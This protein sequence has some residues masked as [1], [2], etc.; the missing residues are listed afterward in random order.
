MYFRHG[1][2]DS[3]LSFT[4][5]DG[6]QTLYLGE[7]FARRIWIPD[8]FFA[9]GKSVQF[10]KLAMTGKDAEFISLNANGDLFMSR[11]YGYPKPKLSFNLNIYLFIFRIEVVAS[12]PMNV[13]NYPFDRQLCT[14]EMESCKLDRILACL[15]IDSLSKSLFLGFFL[16]G[17]SMS[18]VIYSWRSGK[19]A[20]GMSAYSPGP[21]FTICG[22]KQLAK[23]ESLSS[24][25]YSR[26]VVELDMVRN[27]HPFYLRV[28][29]PTFTLVL[30]SWIPLWLSQSSDYFRVAIALGLFLTSLAWNAFNCVEIGSTTRLLDYFLI[31]SS[32]AI[33]AVLLYLTVVAFLGRKP[34]F[35]YAKVPEVN[36]TKERTG[37]LDK[38]V[39]WAFPGLYLLYVLVHI[40][41][42]K[43]ALSFTG[44][45][46]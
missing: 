20:I 33:L 30:L 36:G 6:L 16:D 21:D 7:A 1:W 28:Y 25:N 4:P 44:V 11:M 26:L 5:Q 29:L 17:Y 38:A 10:Q 14:L 12:C 15:L 45:R 46:P 9:N 23:V 32:L 34:N 8:T 35:S 22:F 40:C 2:S 27:S 18:D 3:R 24:G 13:Q 31:H 37:C 42:L 41:A 19:A 39:R 43:W